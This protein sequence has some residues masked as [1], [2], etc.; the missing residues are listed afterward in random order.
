MSRC[1]LAPVS[2]LL[3][4]W[5][6]E[7]PRAQVP[8]TSPKPGAGSDLEVVEKVLMARR[9]YQKSL[10]QLRLHYLKTGDLERSKW[11]EEELRQYHRI[12][13]NSYRLDLDVPPPTLNG[14]TNM[15]EANKLYTL[16]MSYK[17]K[18]WGT[19][20]IDNQRRAE[21]LLQK[22]LTEYPQCNR[23]DDAAYM[24]GDV[25]E[26]KANKQ[27]R[28]AAAYFERCFQWNNKTQLDA[29]LRAARIYDRQLAERARAIE[30]YREITTHETDA[31]R[32]QEASKRLAELSGAK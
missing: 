6:A 16:A 17:D 21:I 25:Y 2:L 30:L 18:G 14:S 13:H 11:A 27:F 29:R 1:W 20:Y 23:I 28:R 12:V 4:L 31:K 10:E 15:P 3:A 9:D 5:I 32:I 8:P 7:G 26:S 19:D 24:L 22:L